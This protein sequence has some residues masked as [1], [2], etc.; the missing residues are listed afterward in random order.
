[1]HKVNVKNCNDISWQDDFIYD[2]VVHH[3]YIA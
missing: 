3:R 1:M 2:E